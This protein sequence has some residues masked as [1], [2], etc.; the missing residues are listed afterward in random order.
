MHFYHERKKKK[1]F[2]GAADA[3]S[4]SKQNF[5]AVSINTAVLAIA[6]KILLQ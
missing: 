6:Y 3:E 2:F 5:T 4:L 1:Y